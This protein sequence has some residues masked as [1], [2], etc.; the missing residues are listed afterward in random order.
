MILNLF[1]A[2]IFEGFEE[3]RGSEPMEVI[4]K[5]L[6]NWERPR[7]E[8]ESSFLLRYDPFNTMYVPLNKALDFIDATW[9][10]FRTSSCNFFFH[11]GDGGSIDA[12]QAATE[13]AVSPGAPLGLPK[14]HRHERIGRYVVNAT[15]YNTPFSALR[16]VQ[17]ALH[18]D[19]GV[20]NLRNL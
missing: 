6:E 12:S 1:I 15:R 13:G 16:E 8:A 5:C 18:P 7:F 11:R 19:F 3:S 17:S 9:K 4:T 10:R 2:V 20:R 14:H